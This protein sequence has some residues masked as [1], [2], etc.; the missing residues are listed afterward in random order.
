[1][2]AGIDGISKKIDPGDSMNENIYSLSES[3]KKALGIRP[4]PSNLELYLN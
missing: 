1:M 3:R 4:L 2:A